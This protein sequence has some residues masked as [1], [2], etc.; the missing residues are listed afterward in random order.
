MRLG[1]THRRVRWLVLACEAGLAY[2]EEVVNAEDEAALAPASRREGWCGNVRQERQALTSRHRH[3]R[4]R[5]GNESNPDN[6]LFEGGA[7]QI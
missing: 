2:S 1:C 4:K 3:R 6:Y 7:H 5:K